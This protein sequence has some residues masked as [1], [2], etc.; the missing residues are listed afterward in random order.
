MEGLL[1]QA[2]DTRTQ[3]LVQKLEEL[4]KQ[5]TQAGAGPAN[6]RRVYSQRMDVLRELVEA[7]QPADRDIWL[8]QLVDSAVVLSQPAPD[9]EGSAVLA[10]IADEVAKATQNNE[11]IAQARF[12]FLTAE[13]SESLQKS[14]ADFAKRH[15]G[16]SLGGMLRPLREVLRFVVGKNL[17]PV[18]DALSIRGALDAADRPGVRRPGALLLIDAATGTL[19]GIFTDADLRRLVLKHAGQGPRS[20][21]NRSRPS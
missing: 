9:G 10:K 16:G 13:Y 4:D 18:S 6:T 14:D 5:L 2:V 11:V 21:I 17:A 1:A 15:P 3:Q 12:A 8:L 20:S 7:S 19:T